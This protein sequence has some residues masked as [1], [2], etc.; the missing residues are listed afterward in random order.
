MTREQQ[1][2]SDQWDE[3]ELQILGIDAMPASTRRLFT[4]WKIQLEQAQQELEL[5]FVD[6]G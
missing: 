2:L 3:I 6:A 4:N 1:L 5:R